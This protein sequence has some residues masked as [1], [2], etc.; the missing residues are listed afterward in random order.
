MKEL[1]S[2]SKHEVAIQERLTKLKETIAAIKSLQT[3]SKTEFIKYTN[4]LYN[5][6]GEPDFAEFKY[7]RTSI[8][9]L[10][11]SLDKSI[12]ISD[13]YLIIKSF[14]ESLNVKRNMTEDQLIEAAATLFRKTVSD[15]Y[16]ETLEDVVVFFQGCKEG[17]YGQI[18]DRIDIQIILSMRENFLNFRHEV[19]NSILYDDVPSYDR[20]DNILSVR[21]IDD[22]YKRR[23]SQVKEDKDRLLNEKVNKI[24]SAL[25]NLKDKLYGNDKKNQQD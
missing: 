12:I 13:I 23:A 17:R 8:L 14:T 7:H 6:N 16:L 2:N 4:S 25:R 3:N 20:Q 24:G 1:I 9:T 18:M 22:E 5:R 21:D 10:S 11:K 19:N 15:G